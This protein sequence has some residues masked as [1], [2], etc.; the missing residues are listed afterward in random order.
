MGTTTGEGSNLNKSRR[1]SD[2][3]TKKIS[4]PGQSGPLKNQLFEKI[5]ATA[6]VLIIEGISGSGKDTFQTYIKKKLK[7]REVHDFSEGE[8]LHS[9]KHLQ[10]EELSK[11]R[12]QFM[13][14]FVNHVRDTIAR[15]KNVVFLL[16]RFHLSTYASTVVPQPSLRGEYEP[17][18][19]ILRS[20]P[21]H[22]FI[23]KLDESEI[24][25]RSLHPERSSAWH[26]FQKQMGGKAVFHNR[27]K[28]QQ[29]LILEAAR[30][31]KIPYSVIKLYYNS[32]SLEGSLRPSK[33]PTVI[34]RNVRMVSSEMN[35]S[36][37]SQ[38]LH[39]LLHDQVVRAK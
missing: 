17:I 36:P 2:E 10:I 23:L 3:A 24:E 30:D 39:P 22:I 5:A 4:V 7:N 32:P 33:A 26:K 20:L 27:L 34:R 28:T 29:E 18:I 1:T 6:Q 9:W 16:N 13:T 21:V 12:L 37:A 8:V 31:Q 15:D 35:L 14:L 25:K 11:V 19:D 38:A